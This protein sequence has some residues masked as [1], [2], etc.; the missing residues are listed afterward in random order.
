MKN[1]KPFE[2]HPNLSKEINQN[3][4]QSEIDGGAWINKMASDKMLVVQTKNT[5]YTIKHG[6]ERGRFLIKGHAKFCPDWTPCWINGSTWGGSLLKM[7]F[8]GRGMHME[9]V[10]E[11][12]HPQVSNMFSR[13]ITTTQIREVEE[14]PLA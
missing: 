11:K 6:E 9:F 1:E 7:G 4:Q 12:D 8:I 3:I 5:L 14:I 13:T 10:L 2:P